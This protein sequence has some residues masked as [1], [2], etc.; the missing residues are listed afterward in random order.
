MTMKPDRS[1]LW[2]TLVSIN[3][4]NS[5]ALGVIIGAVI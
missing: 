1:V 5:L 4:L 3:L 2:L